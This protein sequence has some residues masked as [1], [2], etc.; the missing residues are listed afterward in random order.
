MMYDWLKVESLSGR[1]RYAAHT[2]E[3]FNSVLDLSERIAVEKF[4][5]LNRLVDAQEPEF[6][7]GRVRLPEGVKEAVKAYADSGLL[8]R[9]SVVSGKSVSVLVDHGGR[10]IIQKKHIIKK[11]NT[12]Q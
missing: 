9:K 4:Q 3:T 5:P 8:D 6:Y 12:I 7:Q 2:Q 10:R 1:E 11:T